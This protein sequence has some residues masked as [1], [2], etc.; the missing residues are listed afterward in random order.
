[1]SGRLDQRVQID[2]ARVSGNLRCVDQ[3]LGA[4]VAGGSGR[5][6]A[7]ADPGQGGVIVDHAGIEPRKR[8]GHAESPRVVKMERQVDRR[9]QP[10]G[11]WLWG[12]GSGFGD[13]A[14]RRSRRVSGYRRRAIIVCRKV[15]QKRLWIDR[16]AGRQVGRP[17]PRARA[18]HV[19]S[20]PTAAHRDRDAWTLRQ[21]GR[22]VKPLRP[23]GRARPRRVVPIAAAGGNAP[24]QRSAWPTHFL[25]RSLARTSASLAVSFAR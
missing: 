19:K 15:A 16:D 24:R 13:E 3:I 21:G 5:L 2:A 1:M 9:D 17:Q 22:G 14:L 7:A 10:N 12:L 18:L 25:A 23:T 4:E 20:R 6:G 11:V 8:V